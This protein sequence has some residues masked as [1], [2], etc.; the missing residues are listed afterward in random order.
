MF[1]V[2]AIDPFKINVELDPLVCSANGDGA[3]EEHV[4]QW[5][6]FV[7]LWVFHLKISR[8]KIFLKFV[9][10]FYSLS[11]SVEELT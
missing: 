7:V 3:M 2:T 4:K 10:L 8:V 9:C 11:Y 1:T 5:S 6:I